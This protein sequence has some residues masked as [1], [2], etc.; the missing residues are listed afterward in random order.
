[1]ENFTVNGFNVSIEK[2][3]SFNIIGFTKFVKL[4][5][6]S[7]AAFLNELTETGNIKKLLQT[8]KKT[9]QIWVCLSGNEG[10]ADADCRCTVCVEQDENQNFSSFSENELFSLHAPES[11]WA[12]FEVNEHQSPAE[13]HKND[14]YKMIAEI[15]YKFNFDVGFHLDN[16]HDWK[17]GK[18]MKFLL[19][20]L[21]A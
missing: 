21:K 5:G 17:P 16:E 2:R 6:K 19:P 18:T 13:L 4:D 9:Q 3:P 12:V 11:D 1:M 15:G 20:V 7:I 10:R 8:S 14:V